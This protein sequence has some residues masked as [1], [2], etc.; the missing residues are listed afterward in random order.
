MVYRVKGRVF[1]TL[2]ALPFFAVGA[3]MLVS[4]GSLFHD[5]W[6]MQGWEPVPAQL[7]AAGYETRSGDD[8][9]TYEAYARYG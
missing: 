9:D 7:L 3:W 1:V 4:I 8:S 2:F 6:R 5:A